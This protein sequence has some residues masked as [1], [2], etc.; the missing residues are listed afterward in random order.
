[1]KLSRLLLLTVV[2]GILLLT[3]VWEDIVSNGGMGDI[4]SNGD[5]GILLLTVLWADSA[6]N[7]G[8]GDIASI[9]GIGDIASNDGMRGYLFINIFDVIRIIRP[10]NILILK[11]YILHTICINCDM[12]RSILVI[13]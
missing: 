12:F 6:S 13:F 8:M 9:G 3:V 1:M 2:W 10:T 4:T 5:M 11:L 7:G